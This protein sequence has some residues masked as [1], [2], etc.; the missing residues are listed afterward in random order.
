MQALVA[1]LS[2]DVLALPSPLLDLI[3]PRPPEYP[4]SQENF[5]RRTSPAFDSLA[6]A[7]AAAEIVVSSLL[8]PQRAQRMIEYHARNAANPGF[9][10]LLDHLLASTWKSNLDPGYHGAIQRTVNAVVLSQL[11]SLAADQ[12]ASDQVRAL[13]WLK[14]HE[15]REWL[16]SQENVR[17]EAPARAELFYAENQIDRFEKNPSEVHTTAP[18][19]PPAGDPIGTDGWE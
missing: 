15:L 9:D 8:Q 7:E 6:P 18:A 10:E 12:H 3:P 5:A 14:L 11:M 13:A 4:S 16:R 17:N 2:P 19:P 1:T